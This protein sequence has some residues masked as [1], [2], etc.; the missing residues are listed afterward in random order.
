[1]TVPPS[2]LRRVTNDV[3]RGGEFFEEQISGRTTI[4]QKP[5]S[6]A[7]MSIRF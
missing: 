5:T 2:D 7:K 4:D 6:R 3:E 1:L